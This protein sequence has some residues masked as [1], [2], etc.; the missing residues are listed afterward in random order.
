VLGNFAEAASIQR[1]G[2]FGHGDGRIPG[3]V[4]HFD[5][6]SRGGI[7]IDIVGPDPRTAIISNPTGGKETR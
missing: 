5:A 4:G 6:Q 3:S 1:Q 2:M 7:E